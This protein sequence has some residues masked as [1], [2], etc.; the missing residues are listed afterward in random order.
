MIRFYGGTAEE[1]FYGKTGFVF[2]Q[3]EALPRLQAEESLT[4][5]SRLRLALGAMSK[6]AAGQ[7]IREWKERAG[8]LEAESQAPRFDFTALAG[9]GIGMRSNKGGSTS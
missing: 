9:I 5:V 6:Q 1:W 8:L 2:A 3:M 7:L 4:E